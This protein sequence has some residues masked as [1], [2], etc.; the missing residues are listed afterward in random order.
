MAG[1]KVLQQRKTTVAQLNARGLQTL[2]EPQDMVH[3]NTKLTDATNAALL[4]CSTRR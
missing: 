3:P 2:P 4:Q 1:N